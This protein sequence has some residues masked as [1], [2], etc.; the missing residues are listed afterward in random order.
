M[1][2]KDTVTIDNG[3]VVSADKAAE[4]GH[5]VTGENDEDVSEHQCG[6]FGWTPSY[7]Q[8]F[9]TPPWLLVCMM[10]LM[11]TQGIK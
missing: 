6:Y 3:H 2:D 8:R 4:N 7:L 1:L 5:V 10:V 9:N 11:F